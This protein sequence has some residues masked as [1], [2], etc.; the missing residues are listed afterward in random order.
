MPA[1]P[2]VP[3]IPAIPVAPVSAEPS[4]V[5]AGVA[6]S[7]AIAL[8]VRESPQTVAHDTLSDDPSALGL[9]AAAPGTPTGSVK[10][11]RRPALRGRGRTVVA[12]SGFWRAK[13]EAVL[14]H[15]SDGLIVLNAAGVVELMNP[16]AVRMCGDKCGRPVSELCGRRVPTAVAAP[17]S[18]SRGL[19]REPLRRPSSAVLDPIETGPL[20]FGP[21][22]PA[23]RLNDSSDAG[24]SAEDAAEPSAGLRALA[25]EAVNEH[26]MLVEGPSGRVV[27]SESAVPL[28]EGPDGEVSGAVV[29]LHDISR[30]KAIED[31]L[32]LQR[33][34]AEEAVARRR[35][36]LS[37]LSHDVRGPLHAVVLQTYML[38]RLMPAGAD[39]EML[40]CLSGIEAGIRTTLDL[41][42]DLLNLTRIDG[43]REAAEPTAF[44]LEPTV[45]ESVSAVR[46]LADAKGLALSWEP[47]PLA[48][49]R[50][51]TD[52]AKL[53]Q[54][55]GNLLANAIKYT[56]DGRVDVYGGREPTGIVLCV[57]DTG[58][59]IP[60][61]HADR[62]F[63]EFYRVD[64][65]H[66]PSGDGLGLGLAIARRL[67]SLL[68]GE[69]D[70]TSRPGAG[71]TFRLH[72][73]ESALDIPPDA[74]QAPVKFGDPGSGGLSAKAVA[75]LQAARAAQSQPQAS[76]P[77][78]S[79]G[80]ASAPAAATCGAGTA[81]G[82]P[83]TATGRGAHVAP[84]SDLKSGVWPVTAMPAP[85]APRPRPA[86]APGGPSGG[87]RTAG[88]TPVSA[89]TAAGDRRPRGSILLADDEIAGR[90]GL[91]RLLRA[92]GYDVE[93]A[94]NGHDALRKLRVRRPDVVLMDLNMPVMDGVE[95]IRRA[96]GEPEL[97]G[98]RIIALTGDVTRAAR[99]AAR[100][101]GA[102]GFLEK[103]IE[104]S[105]LRRALSPA[106]ES[107]AT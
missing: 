61:E 16:A 60:P 21:A 95:A 79:P 19:G 86:D 56:S 13:L 78:P 88:G 36:M 52:R 48:G 66:R 44:H 83:G 24:A 97:A 32:L 84:G 94:G 3:A 70:F 105:A 22:E 28:R 47:G 26:E 43:G 90:Q 55:L 99:D 17:V 82:T 50:I 67:A 72:L 65:P 68:G 1:I 80:A 96:R 7:V 6:M 35:R 104:L 103:P 15:M 98:L 51:H 71:C 9:I 89:A 73:P 18:L 31:E 49:L 29:I 42:N 102:D 2:A 101:A 34:L 76:G 63:E 27:V 4:P 41:F 87:P 39:P 8:P 92:L 64:R 12:D 33:R 75:A 40:E 23:G 85:A 53:K 107:A 46:A 11:G 106:A 45:A 25:G 100:D 14:A 30:R 5:A 93:E 59:G 69:L 91:S 54:I 10:L 81:E 37:A 77:A 20:G 62:V 38:R 74:V 57:A 58:P